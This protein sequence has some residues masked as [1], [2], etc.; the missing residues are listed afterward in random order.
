GPGGASTVN[1][2][3]HVRA[4]EHSGSV[5]TV[6]GSIDIEDNAVVAEARTVN[7]SVEVG[8]HASADSVSTVNGA[9]T[10]GDGAHVTRSITTVNGGMNL[11][12]GADVGGAVKNV[13][14]HIRLSAAHVAG[15]LRTVQGDID[16]GGASRVE[17]GILVEKPNTSW[18]S[19]YS[20]KPRIVIGPGAVVQGELRFERDVELYVSDQATVG[21]I[22]GAKAIRFSG[23]SPPAG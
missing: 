16:I 3:I 12:S 4:G 6:N 13:N 19:F 22:Q 8:A 5:G 11:R 1:G 9:V 17:A 21:P 2:S 20:H 23:S 10:L 15:G 14:G 7:G 18:F